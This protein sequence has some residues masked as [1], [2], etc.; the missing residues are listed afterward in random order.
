MLGHAD[1][2]LRRQVMAHMLACPACRAEYDDMVV[3]LDE[4][5]PAVPAVQPPLGFDEQVLAKMGVGPAA[6]RGVM[7]RRLLMA[8]AAVLVIVGAGIGW[9]AVTRDAGSTGQVA[10]LQLVDGG[11]EVGTVSVG[12]VHGRPVMVVA[13][14]DAPQ[15]VSYRCR[16]T[17]ADGSVTVSDPW[18]AEYGAWIVPLPQ[19]SAGQ[20]D[21]VQLVVDGSDHVWSTAEFD[22]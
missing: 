2:Q 4:L 6:R 18:P 5:L 10:A 19:S 22:G 9:W 14:I 17:F 20:I 12:D 1:A 7:Q 15:G 3:T 8:A 16:T 11:N 21:S 13:L